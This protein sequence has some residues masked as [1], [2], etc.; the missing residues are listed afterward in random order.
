MHLTRDAA[1]SVEHHKEE[2]RIQQDRTLTVSAVLRRSLKAAR[3]CTF[4]FRGVSP[5]A[6]DMTVGKCVPHQLTAVL[7]KQ[8]NLGGP[9]WTGSSM[10]YP[11]SSTPKGGKQPVRIRLKTAP[12]SVVA[13]GAR[14]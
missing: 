6:C 9:T 10:L 1:R 2:I 7:Q 12:S 14:A 13:G 3:P 11:M 8:L 4:G 5:A